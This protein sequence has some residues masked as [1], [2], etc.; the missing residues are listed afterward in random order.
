MYYNYHT[1]TLKLIYIIHMYMYNTRLCNILAHTGTH[2]HRH[3][4]THSDRHTHT[5][6]ETF[7]LCKYMYITC[8]PP[9]K[10]ADLEELCSQTE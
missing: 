4:R 10:L 9:K 1:S 5:H 6:T 7:S 8:L 2:E 3:T